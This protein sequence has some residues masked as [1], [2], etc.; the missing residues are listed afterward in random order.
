MS[1]LIRGFITLA[2]S[3]IVINHVGLDHITLKLSEINLSSMIIC[4][5]ILF[6]QLISTSLRWHLLTSSIKNTPSWIK[7]FKYYW[8]GI[9]FNQ[10]LPSSFGGDVMRVYLLQKDLKSKA[11]AFASV[12]LERVI[13]LAT[14]LILTLGVAPRAIR[15]LD[16][17]IPKNFFIIIFLVLIALPL[18]A[19]KTGLAGSVLRIF[20]RLVEESFS[21]IG[22]LRKRPFQVLY[23]GL[24]SL[25]THLLTILIA[26][27]L[28]RQFGVAIDYLQVI[29]PISLAMLISAL[30]V[31]ISS[32]GVRETSFVLLLGPFGVSADIAVATGV[33]MGLGTLI[34]SLV[35]GLFYFSRG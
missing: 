6:L 14:L 24:L 32:W 11:Q 18:I 8:I 2:I 28:L 20:K 23:I 25:T 29:G 27:I 17:S 33:V 4:F 7:M 1:F 15:S 16:V 26:W 35:G 10:A 34:F 31:T 13:G 12:G 21:L 22:G 5:C 30:P 19:Y 9:F 3:Y